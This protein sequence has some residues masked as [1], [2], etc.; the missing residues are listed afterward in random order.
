MLTVKFPADIHVHWNNGKKRSVF[1]VCDIQKVEPN[2]LKLI[3]E[4]GNETLVNLDNVQCIEAY[5]LA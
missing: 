4:S 1:T 3:F 2:W 5:S